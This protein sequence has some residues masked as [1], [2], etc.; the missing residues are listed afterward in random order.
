MGYKCLQCFGRKFL[1]KILLESASRGT[2]DDTKR[3]V[4]VIQKPVWRSRY[5]A[6][7]T[8]R[9]TEEFG[10]E[11]VE[12]PDRL[13]GSRSIP[14]SGFRGLCHGVKWPGREAVSCPPCSAEVKNVGSLAPLTHMP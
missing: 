2:H 9:T 5:S 12:R 13:W 7:A 8:S 11:S 3:Y 1:E 4:T 14:F 10:F 6:Q